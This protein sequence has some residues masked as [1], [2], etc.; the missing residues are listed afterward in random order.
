MWMSSSPASNGKVA[1]LELG[2]DPVEPGQQLVE[3]VLVEHAGSEQ[4]AGMRPGL[5]DVVGS[6]AAVEAQRRVQLPEDGIGFLL[7]ARHGGSL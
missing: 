2:L 7:E 5:A 3:L 1:G 4:G 6:Q